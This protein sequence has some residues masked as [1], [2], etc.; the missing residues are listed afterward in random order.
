MVAVKPAV[1]AGVRQTG[2]I[3]EWF[4]LAQ[5]IGLK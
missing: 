2:A 1:A 5:R 4:I 3:L